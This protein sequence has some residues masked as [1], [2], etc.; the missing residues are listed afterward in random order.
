MEFNENVF[1]CLNCDKNFS[2]GPSLEKHMFLHI[3]DKNGYGTGYSN[4]YAIGS[5]VDTGLP[6]NSEE[7]NRKAITSKTSLQNG[8]ED[9][10]DVLP[11]CQESGF[12]D[13]TGTWK[14]S[15]SQTNS[16]DKLF[17]CKQCGKNFIFKRNLKVHMK[18][19]TGEKPFNLQDHEQ[20]HTG[21]KPHVCKQCGKCFAQ[22]SHLQVHERTHTGKKPHSCEKCGK[23]YARLSSLQTHK[24]CHTGV[25]PYVCRR[26]GNDFLNISSLR[27]HERTHTGN[28]RYSVNN[29]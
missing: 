19:H 22:L 20:T 12:I 10:P 24:R 28:K 9:K 3:H 21:E 2:S 1:P 25:K 8:G 14:I 26:W 23:C 5:I 29:V 11:Q 4:E 16:G 7:H 15:N 27:S 6:I 18:I 13:E 17:V